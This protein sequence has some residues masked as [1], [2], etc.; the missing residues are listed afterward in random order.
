MVTPTTAT[1]A[2]R[3]GQL[4]GV[5]ILRALSKATAASSYTSLWNA[6]GNPAAALPAG[7]T[8]DGLPLSIQIVGPADSEPLIVALSAQLEGAS[9]WLA[10]RP[11]LLG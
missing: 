9:E 5:G 6:L 11:P 2:L 8:A 1:A 3:V 10:R 7:F 4:D